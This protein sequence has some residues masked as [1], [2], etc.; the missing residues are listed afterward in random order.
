MTQRLSPPKRVV[1]EGGSLASAILAT[2]L[3]RSGVEVLLQIEVGKPFISSWRAVKIGGQVT[4]NGYHAIEVARAPVL[5]DLLTN[6]LKAQYKIDRRGHGLVIDDT[7]I[8]PELGSDQWPSDI[9]DPLQHSIGIKPLTPTEIAALLP[10]EVLGLFKSV[11]ARYS[12]S[13]EESVHLLIPWFLP[14]SYLL[15]SVDEGDVY[16]NLVRNG[17]LNPTRIQPLNATF[18]DWSNEWQRKLQESELLQI[19]TFEPSE[20]PCSPTNTVE[21]LFFK[22]SIF[23][24]SSQEYERFC[25]V[26]VCSR[27][28]PR[29]ARISST[30][31]ENPTGSLLLAETFSNNDLVSQTELDQASDLLSHTLGGAPIEHLETLTSRRMSSR[32][33]QAVVTPFLV[34]E[35]GD[36]HEVKFPR[37]GPINMAKSERIAVKAF[38]LLRNL[39]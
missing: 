37:G 35:N 25:E 6:W 3:V 33:N 22:L 17:I 5:T 38:E 28:A 13:W 18:E 31:Q 11:S 20:N 19:E 24:V 34:S 2:L 29:L 1:L 39:Q 4:S 8:D 14:N 15:D 23:E 21:D 30:G 16:R 9:F 36:H 26:L 12:P 7:I 27:L 10:Y 32:S